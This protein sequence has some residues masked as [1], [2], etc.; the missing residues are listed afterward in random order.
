MAKIKAKQQKLTVDQI[1]ASLRKHR[2]IQVLVANELNVTRGAI[3]QRVKASKR[4]QKAIEETK[5]KVLDI[6]EAVLFQKIYD[7][8][9]LTALIFYL[10]C[11]GRDR[12][13]VENKNV[14]IGNQAGQSFRIERVVI[15]GEINKDKD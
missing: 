12:G 7:E 8:K 10:K 2:G 15:D 1:E 4:L 14:D 3:S 11:H 5:Q 13:Y 6:S 9:N